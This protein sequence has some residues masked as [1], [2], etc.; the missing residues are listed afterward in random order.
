M[1]DLTLV[2]LPTDMEKL[3]R[4][5]G[6]RGWTGGAGPRGGGRFD[7]GRA[8]HHLLDE[9]FGPG[10]FRPF[11]LLVPPRRMS[12][13]LYAY[14][15]QPV[16]ALIRRAQEVAPPEHLD[17]LDLDGL[18]GKPMPTRFEAGRRLGFDLRVRPVRRRRA[19]LGETPP[20]V[21]K[22]T[23]TRHREVDAF[24]AEATNA[25]A[26]DPE[27]MAGAGRSREA[28]YLDW[29]AERLDGAAALERATSHLAKFQRLRVARARK[30][31]K[32][33]EGPDAVIHGTLT[34][35]DPA[36][37]AGLLAS[38]VGRHKAYGFGMLLLRP[39]NAAIPT[40]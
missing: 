22:G 18:T 36:A 6:E 9:S 30:G 3:V 8:L 12:G 25:H 39:P 4:W 34:V 32:P 38:G 2:R 20:P 33:V 17:V 16:D 28:V 40:A 19:P 14:T 27:G 31:G 21:E 11:R 10:E 37:F 23:Q 13:N 26:D 35:T 7:E 5:A 15:R 1:T 29:L 24:L